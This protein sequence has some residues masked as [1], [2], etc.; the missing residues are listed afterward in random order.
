MDVKITNEEDLTKVSREWALIKDR[1]K[2]KKLIG[3]GRFGQV[4]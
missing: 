4:L 3:A 1:Y 2:L